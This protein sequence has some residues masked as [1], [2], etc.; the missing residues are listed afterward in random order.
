MDIREAQLQDLQAEVRQL[1]DEVVE[2]GGQELARFAYAFPDGYTASACNLAQY[3]ALRRHDL[4][5]LQD[6]LSEAG[7]TSLGMSESRVMAS[8]DRILDM[9]GRAVDEPEP[10][11]AP[12]YPEPGFWEGGELLAAR[13]QA[14]FGPDRGERP[15][16]VM[17]TLPSAAAV[18][19]GLVREL[20][21]NGMDCARINCAHDDRP[22]WEAMAANVRQA[23]REQGRECRI[24]V[25]LAGPK[26]RTGALDRGPA[27]VHL[28]PPRDAYGRL[29]GVAEVVLVPEGEEPDPAG[30]PPRLPVPGDWL[31]HLR[32]GDRLSLADTRAKDRTLVV[33]RRSGDGGLVARTHKGVFLAA[34]GWL[35]WHRNGG[36]R[37]PVWLGS[38]PFG[39]FPGPEVRVRVTE[40]DRFLL[41][42]EPMAGR[43]PEP[44]ADAE[45][46]AAYPRIACHPPGVIDRLAPGD[47]VW[48]DDGRIGAE[49]EAVD[50]HGAKLRVTQARPQGDR[51]RPDKGL[52]FPDTDLE[53]P[54]LSEKDREDLDFVAAEADLVGFSFVESLA[55]MEALM[56]ELKR[57]D[58]GDLPIL[59]KIETKRGVRSFPEI[60]LGTI[61][62]HP[63]GVVIARGDLAVE[64][65]GERLAEIQEELLWMAEAAHVPVVWATQV[66]ESLAKK[67]IV[68]RAELT[69]A[70]M[71]SRADA[72]LLN[73]GPYIVRAQRALTDILGRMRT[74]QHK[75]GA[76]LRALHF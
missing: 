49:V 61:G 3:Q 8:L 68:S 1:R 45:Q 2:T 75:K 17:V 36:S 27:V 15:A 33:E 28:N 57:R 65:G 20:V 12:P 34:G 4:R 66:L 71:A 58:V 47:P 41:L 56:A 24:M 44:G 7:L 38:F 55:D 5:G 21:A 32:P 48:V 19:Y 70:A 30:N 73:K 50:D 40:G 26:I 10:E 11:R 64:L 43:P 6:R 35:H 39:A 53:L 31:A 25:D 42:R 59:A 23:A 54:P 62:R 74:H 51:L 76:R 22:A 18:D 16:F 67:G 14:L 72:V 29:A 13:M 60:V 63:L 52:N 37:G 46:A 69:D 9:L